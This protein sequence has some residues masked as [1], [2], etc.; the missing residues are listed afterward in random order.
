MNGEISSASQVYTA[1]Q[2]TR[3]DLEKHLVATLLF[4]KTTRCMDVTDILV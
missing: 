4:L 1:G 2:C 3:V